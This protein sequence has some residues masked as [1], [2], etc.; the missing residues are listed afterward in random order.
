MGRT[1][2]TATIIGDND[3]P[4]YGFLVDTGSTHVGLPQEEIDQLRLTPIPDGTI[5]VRTANGIVRRQ[6]YLALGR[7]DGSGFA[8]TVT[9][10]PI[11]LIGYEFLENRGYRVNPVTE[12]LERIPDDEFPPPYQ[13]LRPGPTAIP[14]NP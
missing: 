1:Y 14:G 6:S 10:S 13:L 11:P 5:L 3:S 2:A 12:T 8:A 7:I 9:P 4:E